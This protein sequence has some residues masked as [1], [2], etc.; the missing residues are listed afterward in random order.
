MRRFF[1]RH[2]QVGLLCA[3]TLLASINVRAQT[4]EIQRRAQQ[5][6]AQ[7]K[8]DAVRTQIAQ[9]ALQQHAT[10]AQRDS[11]NATLAQQAQQLNEAA[12]ALLDT[13]AGIE[14]KSAALARLQDQHAALE[15]KLSSQ[16]EALAQLLRAAYA[17]NR[18][19]DLSML[20]GDEDISRIARALAYSRYFQRDRVTRIRALLGDVAR[21]DK[22]QQGIEADQAALR[23]QRAQRLAQSQALEQARDAQQKLLD[24]ADTQLVQQRDKLA[25]LQAAQQD[26]NKLLE[27]LKDV[28]ADIPKQ[29]G[30][31]RPF[32]QLKGALP[33]PTMGAAR[34]GSGILGHGL[35]IATPAGSAVHA[36][37]YGR[38][39]W[40][41]FMRGFGMLVIVDH[42]GGYMSLYGNNEA[43]LVEVGDW[44]MP[45]QTIATVGRSQQQAGAY[46]EIRKD[47]KPVD[48]R[49]WLK[50]H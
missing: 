37:A 8:L 21:L 11:I 17:L 7:Q 41:D 45:G 27:K 3:L 2:F 28:F 15:L 26:L 22:L 9:L 36:V 35:L 31:E 32:V 46:F 18:G 43:A 16:R 5:A 14:A 39:A 34:A 40:A 29:L 12:R 50:P 38:V 42:G 48:V 33:W 6:Q 23:A 30:G 47:G 1:P 24:A 44:V 4:D 25:S 49:K 13:D 19:S 20:L 10:A